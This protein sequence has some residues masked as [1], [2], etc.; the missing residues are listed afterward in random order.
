[1]RLQADGPAMAHHSKTTFAFRPEF[2]A[3]LC[4]LRKR[5]GLTLRALAVL[6]D[7]RVPGAHAQ[8]ARLERGKVKYPSINLIV[9]YLRASGAGFRRCPCH[10]ALQPLESRAPAKT[11]CAMTLGYRAVRT[12]GL[13][14]LSQV[15]LN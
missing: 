3:R 6:M 13:P 10:Q 11:G 7:R 15:V 2:S 8:L 1:M 9:D 12:R 5:R 4:Q 14:A